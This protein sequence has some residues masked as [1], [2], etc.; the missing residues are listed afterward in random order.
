M[1]VNPGGGAEARPLEHGGPEQGVEVHDV[2]A[3]EV[4]HF[5]RAVRGPNILKA[6]ALA[7]ALG[8][9]LLQRSHIAN[10]GVEPNVEVL[11]VAARDLEAEVGG[12]P[13]DVP[14]P[15]AGAEPLLNLVGDLGLERPLLGP[16]FQEGLLLSQ[17]KEVVLGAAELG[18]GLG[19]GRARVLQ[20]RGFVGGPTFFA[21]IAVLVLGAAAGAGALEEA[22]GEEHAL[23]RIKVLRNFPGEDQ[24]GFAAALE[25]QFGAGAVLVAVGGVVDVVVDVK[26]RE[27]LRVGG[28]VALHQGLRRFPEPLRGEHHGRAMAIVGAA[29]DHP[30]PLQLLKAHPDI[31]LDVLQQVP[32]VDIATRVGQ[33]TGDK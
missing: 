5:R 13:A 18:G 28:A 12:I 32:K 4:V 8:Y 30:M 2:L 27:V 26:S 7:P 1:G 22:V 31:G 14:G 16:A 6:H 3:D 20:L 9:Q 23:G 19:E 33:G 17:V 15:Q 24:P 25:N 11:V 29:V 10:G 21:V